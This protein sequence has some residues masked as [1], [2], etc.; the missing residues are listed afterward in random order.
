MWRPRL[1]VCNRG[2]VCPVILAFIPKIQ[3]DAHLDVLSQMWGTLYTFRHCSPMLEWLGVTKCMA[4]ADISEKKSS[5]EPSLPTSTTKTCARVS[6][7]VSTPCISSPI[8]SLPLSCVS[9][10][11]AA[12]AGRRA[13]LMMVLKESGKRQRKRKKRI[14]QTAFCSPTPTDTELWQ[15]ESETAR[16]SIPSVNLGLFLAT[17]L[18]PSQV[19]LRVKGNA[20]CMCTHVCDPHFLTR[21]R[22]VPAI[23]MGIILCWQTISS[24]Q[25]LPFV[26]SHL[27]FFCTRFSL[28]VC[29]GS[30]QQ[31][32]W[33][34]AVLFW[35]FQWKSLRRQHQGEMPKHWQRFYFF[36]FLRVGAWR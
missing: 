18:L 4:A 35:C 20:R 15:K 33:K 12:A 6:L 21:R 31:E 36:L 13:L 29:V 24:M 8:L 3:V 25:V 1:S 2:S 22:L 23:C 17:A 27:P 10:P 32:C 9:W 14:W 30:A 5:S 26:Y 7:T 28:Y 11:A 34:A 19:V 16:D